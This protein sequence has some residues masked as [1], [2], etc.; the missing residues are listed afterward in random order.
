MY[1]KLEIEPESLLSD[2]PITREA[3]DS[4][5]L[6]CKPVVIPLCRPYTSKDTDLTIM[7]VY[8]ILF[9]TFFRST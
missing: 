3:Q 1:I 2:Q 7:P 5:A 9:N 6:Q 4:F 8:Y